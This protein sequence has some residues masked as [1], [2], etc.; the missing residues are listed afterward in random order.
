MALRDGNNVR[1][2][3]TVT[4]CSSCLAWG[5]TYS[6]G[7]CLGCYNF[8]VVYKVVDNCGACGRN[9]LLKKGYCRLCWCQAYRER[10]LG[11]GHPLAPY[12][13]KVRFQQLFFAEVNP[14]VSRRHAPPAAFPRRRG[15]KGRPLKP[16][17]LAVAR[18]RVLHVQ[19]QL[20]CASRRYHYGRIDLRNG[21]PPDNPW[22]G[23]ALHLAHTMAE[24]RGFSPIVRS[25][26]QRSLVMLLAGHTGGEMIYVSEFHDVLAGRGSSVAHTSEVLGLMEVLIDDRPATFDTWLADKLEG[27]A[28]TIGS[29]VERWARDLHDGGPRV[30]ARDENTVQ[31]WVRAVRPA[32][33]EWSTGYSHLRE[34]THLD[35]L[36][37]T[38]S[39]VGH[40]RQTTMV[41]LKSLFTWAKRNRVVFSNPAA[42]IKVGRSEWTVWQPLLP[43]E[44][45]RTIDAATTPHTRLFVALAAVHA[46]RPGA[47][48]GLQ[49]ADVDLAN[50]RLTIAGRPRPL[51]T[52]THR[53]LV[54]WLDYRRH[55][56]PITGN[57]HLF[58]S[59]ESA[60][61]LGPVSAPWVG[62]ILRGLPATLE[63]MRIDRQLEEALVHG[64]DP[65]HVAAVFDISNSAAIR[66]A[67][68]ARQLL[69]RPHEVIPLS[70][71][72]TQVFDDTIEP[73]EHLGSR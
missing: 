20:F 9:E 56:W 18:P 37:H 25:A 48:R 63:R 64:A 41:A 30:R 71:P 38:A 34:V 39:L 51:D 16:P 14:G 23:Y 13:A 28:P 10:P 69:E 27:F 53:L 55:R 54:E 67:E 11:P 60:L 62:R 6:Q 59:R 70:S 17:P 43:E 12:V 22:L 49:L 35:V 21:P 50:H 57:Q 2:T 7:V 33:A 31:M 26:L 47:I 4:N 24:N 1:T 45:A 19:G 66:Y 15:A 40:K 68:S 36:A 52:L 29:E 5:M 58:V 65:L 3:Q 32:L 42:R 72:R 61:K 44:I 73:P 46:A 8:A